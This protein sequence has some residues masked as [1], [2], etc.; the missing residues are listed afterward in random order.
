MNVTFLKALIALVP[1]CALFAGVTP[2]SFPGR[3]YY[4]VELLQTAAEHKSPAG[5][6]NRALQL[7]ILIM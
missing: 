2:W 4:A 5:T 3:P 6:E 7:D 1:A